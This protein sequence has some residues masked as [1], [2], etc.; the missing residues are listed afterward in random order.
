MSGALKT[1]TSFAVQAGY[2]DLVVA[3]AGSRQNQQIAEPHLRR[4]TTLP[5]DGRLRF[6]SP[7]QHV[8]A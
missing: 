4:P 2:I 8:Q 7:A 3:G 6:H 1:T 5:K